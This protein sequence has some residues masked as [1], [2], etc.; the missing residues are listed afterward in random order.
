MEFPRALKKSPSEPALIG[1]GTASR[2]STSTQ[3]KIFFFA[4]FILS[5]VVWSI[6]ST[7]SMARRR[8]EPFQGKKI[9]PMP[10]GTVEGQVR[11]DL[12]DNRREL[13]AM[14]GEPAAK[15]YVRV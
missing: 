1:M 3:V 5:A 14:T 6:L 8:R 13:K 4:M 10:R 2:V 12:S 9:D 11:G 15:D 7:C